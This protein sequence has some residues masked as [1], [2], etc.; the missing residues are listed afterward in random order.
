[1]VSAF[2]PHPFAASPDLG[3]IPFSRSRSKQGD[4]SK[5]QSVVEEENFLR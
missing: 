3:V 2:F 1:M 5:S 4:S